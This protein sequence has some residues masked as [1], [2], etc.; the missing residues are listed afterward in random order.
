LTRVLASLN[1]LHAFA[2]GGWKKK[3]SFSWW[4]SLALILAC[5][6]GCPAD[7]GAGYEMGV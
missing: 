1:G 6:R 3:L 2:C 4:K 7:F 5:L